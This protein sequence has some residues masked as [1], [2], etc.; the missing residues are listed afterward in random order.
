MI[1]LL[2]LA[3]IIASFIFGGLWAL[4]GLRITRMQESQQFASDMPLRYLELDASQFR[5]MH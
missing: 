4:A 3:W 2:F 5:R 1:W